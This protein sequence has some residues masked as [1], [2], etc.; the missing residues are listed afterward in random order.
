MKLVIEHKYSEMGRMTFHESAVVGVFIVGIFLWM[1]HD[2]H[3]MSGWAHYFEEVKPKAAS[4]AI[5]VIVIMFLI[6][7][8][9]TSFPSKGLIDWP[10]M[11]S[12]LAW[13]VTIVRGGGFSLADAIEV[14]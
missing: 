14:I 5:F 8:K 11:Q 7:A 13:G 1:F 6:P 10:T 4:A 9:P 3:F 2:P 12:K